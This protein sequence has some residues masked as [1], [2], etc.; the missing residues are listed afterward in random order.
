MRKEGGGGKSTSFVTQDSPTEE[1]DGEEE[2]AGPFTN[3]SVKRERR[4]RSFCSI[5][6]VRGLATRERKG[7]KGGGDVMIVFLVTTRWLLGRGQSREKE[8]RAVLRS[9]GHREKKKGPCQIPSPKKKGKKS[10]ALTMVKPEKGGE[11]G[12]VFEP[13]GGKG[14][15]TTFVQ[16]SA[17]KRKVFSLLKIERGGRKKGK[18]ILS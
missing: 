8:D 3:D 7:K 6:R 1:K 17:E 16:L 12:L 15:S 5:L 14:G 11:G 13:K 4:E 9:P 18:R 2:K 10:P